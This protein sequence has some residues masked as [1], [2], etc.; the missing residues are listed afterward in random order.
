ML[1]AV[2][3]LETNRP[4]SSDH[5]GFNKM[6]TLDNKTVIRRTGLLYV[7]IGSESNVGR[8]GFKR[9]EALQNLHFKR[10]KPT[11]KGRLNS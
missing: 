2:I 5:G 8:G 3:Q 7:F 4:R 11:F 6:F 1:L 9:S 10:Y